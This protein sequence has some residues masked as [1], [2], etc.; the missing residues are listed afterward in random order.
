MAQA[1]T[2]SRQAAAR[3][4]ARNA[5]LGAAHKLVR[6]QG[7]NATTVDQLCAEAGVTKGAFFHHF[8]SKDELGVEAAR[9]WSAVTGAL[10]ANAPYHRQ[11][12]PLQ[13][14]FGYL[15]FRATLAEGPLES[16]TCF[17]GTAVQE[18]YATSEPMR[19]ALGATITSHA[20]LLAVDFEAVIKRYP[21]RLKV[22]AMGLAL[23]TQTVLQGG[24]VLAKSTGDRA[25]LLDA[26]NHL[27]NYLQ[28]LFKEKG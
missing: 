3:G 12:D 11:R 25:P 1:T 14:I 17:A 10:F 18:V 13:R 9:H 26:I 8:A 19:S 2:G 22:S 27:K 24:F 7:W 15:E 20:G 21:P 6:R 16:I 4:S 23:Y 5:L 28:M